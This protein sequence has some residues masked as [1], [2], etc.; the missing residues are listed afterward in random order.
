MTRQLLRSKIHG[1]RVTECDLNY[2]GSCGLGPDLREAA[3]LL[4]LE[5]ISVVNLNTGARTVTYIIADDRPGAITL[6]GAAARRA[7]PGDSV[8]IMAHADLAEEEI[9]AH[10]AHIVILDEGNAIVS[11][12]EEAP[13]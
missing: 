12:R 5:V 4:A 3:G 11:V 1:G 13:S 9:P 8:I 2:E 7:A 6:N 10:R